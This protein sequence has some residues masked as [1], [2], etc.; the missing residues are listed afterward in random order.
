MA[1]ISGEVRA[2][3]IA[4]A[5]S[6]LALSFRHAYEYSKIHTHNRKGWE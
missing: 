6:F 4:V 1:A 5:T 2:F 3:K